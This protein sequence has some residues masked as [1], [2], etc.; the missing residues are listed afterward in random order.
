LFQ[1]SILT[2]TALTVLFWAVDLRIRP[3]RPARWSLRDRILELASLPLIAVLTVLCVALPVL[4][5]QTRLMLGKS[6]RFRVSPKT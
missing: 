4:H 2:I 6:I 1:V 5:A 3:S